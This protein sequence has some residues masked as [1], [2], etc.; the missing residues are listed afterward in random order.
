LNAK[1]YSNVRPDPR[2]QVRQDFGRPRRWPLAVACVVALLVGAGAAT[3]MMHP[4]VIDRLYESVTGSPPPWTGGI[5]DTDIAAPQ[6]QPVPETPL[7]V[8]SA[9]IPQPA[10]PPSDRASGDTASAPEASPSPATPIPPTPPAQNPSNTVDEQRVTD[11]AARAS[12]YIEQR[13]LTTPPGGNAFEVYQQ[14]TQ[15]APQHPKATAILGAIKD[16]YLRW[17]MT[18]EERGQ[19]DNA[20][21]FYRRG[22]SVDPGDQNFQTHLRNLERKRQSALATGTSNPGE[23]AIAPPVPAPDQ[24]LRLPPDY[25][26][27]PDVQA[28][29]ANQPLPPANQFATREDMIQAFQ[30]SGMLQSVIQSGRDIDFELPDGKTA[31]MLASEQGN[32]SAVRQLLAAGAAPNARSRNGGTA[33]MYAASI[34]SSAV[35]RTLLQSGS[36]VNSMNVEGRTALMAAAA[37]G[38]VDTVKILLENGAN[39]GTTSVHGRTALDYAQEGGH[40]A[41]VNLLNS[42]DP[43]AAPRRSSR[44]GSEVGQLN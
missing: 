36:A 28:A 22:L 37:G 9:P 5:S 20:A 27:R 2:Y 23:T 42:F 44:G 34:G 25:D 33:L 7:S 30:Q 18:A 8:P 17:G 29:P 10:L 26:D 4:D 16:S 32:A 24:I 19:F 38:H 39:V 3:T 40:T 1:A 13:L 31:L 43:Q 35:V 11:L 15:I 41:V 14:I 21:G 12:R 6:P